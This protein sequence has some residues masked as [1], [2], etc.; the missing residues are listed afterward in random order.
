MNQSK[1][2]QLAVQRLVLPDGRELINQVVQ[3]DA[4]GRL[5]SYHPLTS[6]IAF[7]QWYRGVWHEADSYDE[8]VFNK[9]KL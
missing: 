1:V 6:E 4:D 9:I 7:C 2:R 3:F 5:T 8:L